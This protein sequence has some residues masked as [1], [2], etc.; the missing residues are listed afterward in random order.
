MAAGR[1][2]GYAHGPS[3][4]ARNR[5]ASAKSCRS[6]DGGSISRINTKS[7]NRRQIASMTETSIKK[8]RMTGYVG[9]SNS[10]SILI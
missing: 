6:S 3:L 1:D 8:M 7:G 10:K 5:Q 9:H 4:S 2:P